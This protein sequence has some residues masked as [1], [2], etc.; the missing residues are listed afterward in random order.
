MVLKFFKKDRAGAD[1]AG[2]DGA[3]AAMFK[4][5]P[6]KARPWFERARTVADTRNYDYAI[7]CFLNGLKHDLDNLD[8]HEALHEVAM[9]RK[10]NGGKPAGFTER[11]FGG[12]KTPV[13]K[14]LHAE[15]LWAKDPTNPSLMLAVMERLVELDEQSEELHLAEVAWWVGSQILETAGAQKK[16]GKATW[17]RTMELFE[18][19]GAYDKAIEACRRALQ[20]TDSDAELLRKFKDLQATDTMTRARYG[21]GSQESV[22]DIDKQRDLDQQDQIA[23]TGSAQEELV[24]RRRAEYEEDPQDVDRAQ[25][26]INTLL[27]SDQKEYEDEAVRI[28]NDIWQQTGQYRHKMRIGDVKIRQ[29]NRSLR[30][31]RDRL[32]K[33]PDDEQARKKF[34]EIARQQIQFELGEYKERVKNYPTD[35]ALR[36][37]LGRRLY[38]AKQ[39]DEAI[40]EFQQARS[41]P[42][43]RAQSLLYLGRCYATKGWLDESLDALREAIEVHPNTSDRPGLEMRY[44]LMDSLER[45]AREHRNIEQAREAQ[46]I[47][48]DILQTDINY[49]DIRDRLDKIRSLVQELEGAESSQ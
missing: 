24:A 48:S 28:L 8:M 2:G 3:A 35:M 38:A 21:E 14:L 17:V 19:V 7:E 39:I 26:L 33:Q 31:L 29:F 40:A 11:F 25:K 6:K 45:S 16:P 22:K 47:A 9:K 4:R 23:R 36:F 20:L 10:L 1:K 41:D 46:K 27:E 44:E 32:T 12:G 13:E 30:E 37:H 42:K 15:L 5:D 49:R 34:N 43:H 18:A